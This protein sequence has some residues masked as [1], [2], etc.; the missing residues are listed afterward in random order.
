MHDDYH[1]PTKEPEAIAAMLINETSSV[2]EIME[3][4]ERFYPI[5]TKNRYKF[6]YDQDSLRAKT[7]NVSPTGWK[8]ADKDIVKD[9]GALV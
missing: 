6:V 5:S 1:D 9:R 8:T 2:D 3:E 4:L 7:A